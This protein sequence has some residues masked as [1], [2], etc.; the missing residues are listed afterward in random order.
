[1]DGETAELNPTKFIR[2]PVHPRIQRRRDLASSLNY[3]A[4]LRE[5][6][7]KF[8]DSQRAVLKIISGEVV[9]HGAC[10]LAVD[11]IAD[12]STISRRV[13]MTALHT[14]KAEGLIKVERPGGRHNT[15]TVSATWRAW[16][17]RYGD[18][19]RMKRNRAGNSGMRT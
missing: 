1:M 9:R 19:P 17:D 14:A 12:L 6:F 16:L 7:R 10:T 13:V 15:I 5:T 4:G 11:A 2:R 8:T 18:T 3:P